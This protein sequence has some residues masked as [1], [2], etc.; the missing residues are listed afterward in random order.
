MLIEE[1]SAFRRTV[2]PAAEPVSLTE[3]KAQLRVDASDEDTY[4]T[5]LIQT[6]REVAEDRTGRALLS[7]TWL[8][9]LDNGSLPADGIVELPRP[10]LQSISSITYIDTDGATQALASSSYTLDTTS[11]PGR[12]YFEDMPSIKSVMNALKITYVAGYSDADAVP[13]KIK[14]GI[15]LLIG[16][17]FNHR[18]EVVRGMTPHNVPMA[19]EAVFELERVRWL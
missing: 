2:D 10:P 16:H 8:A 6:A 3:A 7:Q 13:M 12:I 5:S 1:I 11:E 4:I 14:Q 17:W 15:L 9:T 19:A 18:E